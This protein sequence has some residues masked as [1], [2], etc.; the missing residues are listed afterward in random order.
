M[1]H[2]ESPHFLAQENNQLEWGKILQV[3]YLLTGMILQ[4]RGGFLPWW[5]YSNDVELL[6]GIMAT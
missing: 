6:H 5:D 4:V 1:I 3:P 2:K